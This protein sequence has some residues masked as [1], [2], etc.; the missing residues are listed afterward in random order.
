MKPITDTSLCQSLAIAGEL[1]ELKHQAKKM[2]GNSLFVE[3]RGHCSEPV[4][5]PVQEQVQANV[6]GTVA[7]HS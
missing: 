7:E 2:A 5:D 6:A 3:R 4:Q 1:S